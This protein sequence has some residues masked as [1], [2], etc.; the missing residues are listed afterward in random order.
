MNADL[1]SV[2]PM[3]PLYTPDHLLVETM[4]GDIRSLR[5][6]HIKAIVPTSRPH[7]T[8]IE[9]IDLLSGRSHLVIQEAPERFWVRCLG[10][11]QALQDQDLNSIDLHF[12]PH[13]EG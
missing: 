3:V 8:R 9:F 4:Q 1:Y 12:A 7:L 13:F 11:L 6:R 10:M 5:I 2:L